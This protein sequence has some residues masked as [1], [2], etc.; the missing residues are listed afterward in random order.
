MEYYAV[1]VLAYYLYGLIELSN[2][3]NW[4]SV[5]GVGLNVL[6]WSPFVGRALGWW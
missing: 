3:K 2:R 6:I 1:I 5:I 4:S